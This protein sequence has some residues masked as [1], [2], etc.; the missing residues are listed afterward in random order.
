ML[1]A[2]SIETWLGVFV[3]TLTI[4]ITEFQIHDCVCIINYKVYNFALKHYLVT[5]YWISIQVLQETDVGRRQGIFFIF[6]NIS[7]KT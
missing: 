3:F 7:F 5:K 1:S 4:Q 2:I 6:Q